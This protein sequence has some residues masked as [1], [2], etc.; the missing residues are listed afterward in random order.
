MTR[1]EIEARI[2]T[3]ETRA[4]YINMVDHWTRE[5]RELLHKVEQEIKELKALLK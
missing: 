3:L 5:D 2:D 1:T 4:F